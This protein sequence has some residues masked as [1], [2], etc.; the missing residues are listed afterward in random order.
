MNTLS[1]ALLRIARQAQNRGGVAGSIYLNRQHTD[2][3]LAEMGQPRD[4]RLTRTPQV[5]RFNDTPLYP[6]RDVSMVVCHD[7]AGEAYTE[8]L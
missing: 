6:D 4:R 2:Q 3:L 5:D 7:Q 8:L 1:L